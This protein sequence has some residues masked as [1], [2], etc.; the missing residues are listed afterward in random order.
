MSSLIEQAAQR[1]EQLRRAGVSVPQNE[2]VDQAQVAPQTPSESLRHSQPPISG[3]AKVLSGEDGSHLSSKRVELNLGDLQAAGFVTPNAERSRMADQYRVIKRPLISNAMGKGASTL[4]HGN[5]I[6]VTSALP[7]EGKTF[8]S[9]N[10]ALSIAA[11]LDNSVM[12]VDA[13]VARPS[14]LR[15]FGLPACP[16]LLDL[17]QGRAEM[18]NVLLRTNVD[19]LTLLP[20][21]YPQARATELLASDAMRQLLDDMAQ[22]YSD[23]IIIFDSPPLLLTT[24]SR[25]LAT[26]MGQIV[27]VVQAGKT[28]QREVQHALSA[29]DSCPVKLMLLN[30]ASEEAAGDYSYGYSY[31]YGRERGKDSAAV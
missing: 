4:N 7:G 10:L 19:K 31:A 17:L 25:A 6:M 14:L 29:I 28:L 13:D 16:G 30:Q 21:G 20:S 3:G 1:L 27:V 15:T 18:S 12:L 11:E 22:R 24:E 26:H 2:P 5:L 8:T 23:R 9:I